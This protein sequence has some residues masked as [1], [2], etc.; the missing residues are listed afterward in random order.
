MK[1]LNL[2]CHVET[3]I[4]LKMAI[5][6]DADPGVHVVLILFTVWNVRLR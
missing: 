5:V 2:V 4:T 3:V 1:V 6:E